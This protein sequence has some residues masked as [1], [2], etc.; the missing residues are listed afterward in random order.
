MKSGK[1][2]IP[3]KKAL[4]KGFGDPEVVVMDVTE[5][6]IERPQKKQK[7][8][9][10]GKKKY[11]SLKMQVVINQKTKE[12]ICLHF[13]PGHCHDFNL[14]KNSPVHFHPEPDSLQDSGYQG[15]KKYHSNSY[16]PKKKPK[17]GS[18][19]ALQK[20]Y[21]LALSQDIVGIK[22]I[23]RSLKIFKILSS[24]YRNR[25][26]RYGLRCNL[27]AALYNYELALGA[28]IQNL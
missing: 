10:S 12:I 6:A 28:K 11:H 26:R 22:H 9:F 15:I 3:G 24:R 27:L 21:H 20:D 25:R 4:L 23:N 7:K 19:F 8:Y 16:T 17:K 14:F 18:L 1:L 2:R 5:T 13:G